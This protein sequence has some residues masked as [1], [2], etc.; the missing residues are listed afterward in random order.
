MRLNGV[1]DDRTW[2]GELGYGRLMTARAAV[3]AAVVRDRSCN[4]PVVTRAARPDQEA[5]RTRRGDARG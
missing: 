2:R 3:F 5:K 4:A 1:Q